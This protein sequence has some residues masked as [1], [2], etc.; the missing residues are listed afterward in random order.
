MGRAY[1]SKEGDNLVDLLG[2][3]GHA[4]EMTSLQPNN[5]LENLEGNEDIN[6]GLG[7]GA[8]AGANAGSITNPVIGA[9]VSQCASGSDPLLCTRDM[10]DGCIVSEKCGSNMWNTNDGDDAGRLHFFGTKN[11]EFVKGNTRIF[12]R[13]SGA[14]STFV[15]V[16]K[17]VPARGN[18]GPFAES[19]S[20][21]MLVSQL[22]MQADEIA[23][24]SCTVLGSG[25]LSI[26]KKH[27]PSLVDHS[28]FARS[29]LDEQN[30]KRGRPAEAGDE[31]SSIEERPILDSG[32]LE[33][34]HVVHNQDVFVGRN[35]ERSAGIFSME[36]D[37]ARRD[38]VATAPDRHTVFSVGRDIH[39]PPFANES[40]PYIQSRNIPA[41]L[42]A[43]GAGVHVLD[44][45]GVSKHESLPLESE[46]THNGMNPPGTSMSH[47]EERTP[48]PVGMQH[49]SSHECV[50]V[51]Q[52]VHPAKVLNTECMKCR[53]SELASH[54]KADPNK[55]SQQPQS[56][57]CAG[58]IPL[59]CENCRFSDLNVCKISSEDLQSRAMS[60][61][62]HVL[63]EMA[64]HQLVCRTNGLD[65]VKI[66]AK[67]HAAEFISGHNQKNMMEQ[68]LDKDKD[69]VEPVDYTEAD[70]ECEAKSREKAGNNQYMKDSLKSI[71]NRERG[72]GKGKVKRQE[73]SK[74]WEDERENGSENGAGDKERDSESGEG[75]REKG[76]E[77]GED[78][79]ESAESFCTG[80]R[81]WISEG[82]GYDA[83]RVK[84]LKLNSGSGCETSFLRSGNSSFVNW[85]LN[86]RKGLSRKQPVPVSVR[87]SLVVS[88]QGKCTQDN[89]GRVDVDHKTRTSTCASLG[90]VPSLVAND[91]D[92]LKPKCLHNAECNKEG[93]EA[94][95]WKRRFSSTAATFFNRTSQACPI[96]SVHTD[97]GL[98]HF[99]ERPLP[100]VESNVI[101]DGVNQPFKGTQ[102]K[103][104]CK[105]G[106]TSLANPWKS[107]CNQEDI[108]S[109]FDPLSVQ[110]VKE[111][112]PERPSTVTHKK[113]NLNY[114]QHNASTCLS[115]TMNEG[116]NKTTISNMLAARFSSKYY[117]PVSGCL[118]HKHAMDWQKDV[119]CERVNGEDEMEN[120]SQEI[121]RNCH[122]TKGLEK[123]TQ[124]MDN[125]SINDA[126]AEQPKY[127]VHSASI[128][129][130][131]N[132]IGDKFLHSPSHLNF[133]QFGSHCARGDDSGSIPNEQGP[134]DTSAAMA[135]VKAWRVETSKCKDP[136]MHAVPLNI[137]V[138]ERNLKGI[139]IFCGLRGHQFSECSE[140][141]D[142]ELGELEKKIPIWERKRERLGSCVCIRC[143]E[144]GHWG[145]QCQFSVSMGSSHASKQIESMA[146][147][148]G[149]ATVKDNNVRI[150]HSSKGGLQKMS[151]GSKIHSL[152][153]YKGVHAK[154]LLECGR[155]RVEYTQY[156]EASSS[157]VPNKLR[158]EIV[159]E[160][161][162]LSQVKAHLQSDGYL[163]ELDCHCQV[164]TGENVTG[165]SMKGKQFG[166]MPGDELKALGGALATP[167]S[168]KDPFCIFSGA[169]MIVPKGMLAE[170]EM[171]R[172]SRTDILK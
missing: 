172:L 79:R 130:A 7:S 93:V 151:E 76:S 117:L 104:G 128:E 165:K 29:A 96:P 126:L 70:E 24:C 141:L 75:E 72:S 46:E 32:R 114:C 53:S 17:G 137:A 147:N 95:L 107:A 155:K 77:N 61:T 111:N 138:A 22:R 68:I 20:R 125:I 158:Q 13:T 69:Y 139:C 163:K 168:C 60:S 85:F 91:K 86:L 71:H 146:T 14:A 80:K 119:P 21:S 1:D 112:L 41:N 36:L 45:Q 3:T 23:S 49:A 74:I 140:M 157:S 51:N 166:W 115:L 122:V 25:V 35:D 88:P 83:G 30:C 87:E 73:Q 118:Q 171:I 31:S 44:I 55:E 2:A 33:Q 149:L 131:E 133:A 99:L 113:T 101:E 167:A 156:I 26:D 67:E 136:S 144:V 34:R 105:R 56:T 82:Q 9:T 129:G 43:R 164:A 153:D 12:D 4:P 135:F 54:T 39:F 102:S 169:A 15:N 103:F 58:A 18:M 11:L 162:Q 161:A 160:D 142:C 27:I 47:S 109:F 52:S 121:G 154:H 132:L 123:D 98:Q 57:A 64:N 170:I 10:T 94:S 48:Q 63:N 66:C 37:E 120:H 8:G 19:S 124:P 90:G 81:E 59:Y 92:L 159:C 38:L 100:H 134:A 50:S 89:D 16:E 148:E 78:E 143:L 110:N 6:F 40:R 65:A 5:N 116:L 150:Y 84:L 62:H 28:K 145:I 106:N 42:E 127:I 97:E 108:A 152:H